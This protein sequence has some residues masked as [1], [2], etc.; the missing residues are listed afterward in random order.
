MAILMQAKSAKGNKK[1]S[2]E[3]L[4]HWLNEKSVNPSSIYHA[5]FDLFCSTMRDDSVPSEFNSD[6][7]GIIPLLFKQNKTLIVMNRDYAYKDFHD[8]YINDTSGI[9]MTEKCTALMMYLSEEALIKEVL[10]KVLPE[11]AKKI[12]VLKKLK[13]KFSGFALQNMIMKQAM[14][15]EEEQAEIAEAA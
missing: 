10:P 5:I 7:L 3:Q 13:P 9:P 2:S 6:V 11:L 4:L 12:A 14:K 1:Y 8:R 15:L